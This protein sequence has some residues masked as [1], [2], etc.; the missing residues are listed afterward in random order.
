MNI[1]IVTGASSGM[2]KDFVREL[3]A[4]GFDEIWAI[5]RREGALCELAR[6][7][8]TPV[9][10][11]ALDLTERESLGKIEELLEA[12]KPRVG[13][14]VCAAGYGRF[15]SFAEV[16][17]DESERIIS[18]NCT[19]LVRLTYACVGYMDRGSKI[20]EIASVA[21]FQPLPYLNIY[22]A[23][24]AFVL[25]FSEALS[26]ELAD[27]GITVTALCPGWVRT[28]FIGNAEKTDASS[29]NFFPGMSESRSVVRKALRFCDR[30]KRVCVC[31]S[32]SHM[33]H[34][35]TRIL[36]VSLTMRAWNIIRRKKR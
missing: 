12:E 8:K 31:G 9:R 25:S 34:L 18:L 15:G 11:L 7:V 27:R 16:D 28:E 17:D 4:Y 29:V 35:F 10:V 30:G 32:L 13:Y 33:Q 36:P 1:A 19:S 5:A 3:D 22:A 2:G 21:A 14:L 26:F 24:K 23:T 6:E 20:I